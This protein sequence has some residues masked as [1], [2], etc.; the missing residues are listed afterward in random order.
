[1]AR[2]LGLDLIMNGGCAAA[3]CKIKIGSSTRTVP[4][5]LL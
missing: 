5:T 2:G 4:V 3:C 1:M